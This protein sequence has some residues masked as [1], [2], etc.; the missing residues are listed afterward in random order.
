M[1]LHI[2]NNKKDFDA[3][4]SNNKLQKTYALTFLENKTLSAWGIK[5]SRISLKSQ[6][7]EAS[8]NKYSQS[9][10]QNVKKLND[11]N[12]ILICFPRKILHNSFDIAN[13]YNIKWSIETNLNFFSFCQKIF[14]LIFI[15]WGGILIFNHFEHMNNIMRW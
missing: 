3:S 14:C 10:L 15:T 12:Y 4:G 13:T 9:F 8:S 2:N 5:I 7:E 6:D 1:K 11:I